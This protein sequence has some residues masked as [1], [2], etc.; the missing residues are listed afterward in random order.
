MFNTEAYVSQI[1]THSEIFKLSR[2]QKKS[3]DHC[4]GCI[5]RSVES[6][7]GCLDRLFW[8]P[9]IHYW[10]LGGLNTECS[11]RAAENKMS[12]SHN[13]FPS[14]WRFLHL[15]PW[16]HWCCIGWPLCG[17]DGFNNMKI[18]LCEIVK[19]KLMTYIPQHLQSR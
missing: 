2:S 3:Q 11:M 1:C 19:L 7:S 10:Y 8:N 17:S 16:Q 4:L 18:F 9:H 15:L 6:R 14:V 13:F 5:F 12:L